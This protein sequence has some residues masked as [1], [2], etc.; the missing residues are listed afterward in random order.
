MAEDREVVITGVGS[1]CPLGVG[2]EAVFAALSQMRGGVRPIAE[3]VDTQLPTHFGAPITDDFDPKQLIRPRKSL[4]I[5]CREIQMGVA[6]AT[7]A[8]EHAGLTADQ[9][10][11][12]RFGVVYASELFFGDLA[13]IE[14]AF[15]ECSEHGEF[16]FPQ[17]GEQAMKHL[18]P[19]WMLKYLPNMAACHVGIS[20]D[21]RG[22]NNTITLGEVSS[23]L[24]VAESRRVIQRGAADC[25]IAGGCGTRLNVNSYLFRGW[26]DISTRNS[27]PEKASRPFDAQREGIVI[28]EG[29]AS[30]MLESQQHAQARGAK[31]YGRILSIVSGFDPEPLDSPRHGDA[32]ARVIRRALEAAGIGPADV[33]H[34]NAHGL[35]H[36]LRD[37]IEARAIRA[38]LGDCPVTA[39]KSYHGDMGPGSGAMEL[40]VSLLGMEHDAIAPIL[41]YTQ[42]DPS[43]P[44]NAIVGQP[45]TG[46]KKIAVVLNQ[47]VEGQTVAAVI[48]GE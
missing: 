22:P 44:I 16:H 5:M 15:Q 33:G 2:N 48:A 30:L 21:A 35:S 42:A 18:Y 12:D 36:V 26:H 10:D 27:A 29:A 43:C 14:R 9:I 39:P 1:V 23:L 45:L 8:L 6:S 25:M 37:Q 11:S 13:E 40:L 31:I 46:A 7:L 47:N 20:H 17:W 38:A 41:N 24:A 3:W 34:V 32:T 19:L 4:K 28:G